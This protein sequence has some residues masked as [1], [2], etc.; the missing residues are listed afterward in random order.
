[1]NTFKRQSKID[2]AM[3]LLL[4][5]ITNKYERFARTSDF[6]TVEDKVQKFADELNVESGRKYIKIIAGT[7]VWGF[8][9]IANPD[10][11]YGDILKSKNWKTPALNQA[12]GN[13]FD[14]VYSID[15]TGPLYISGY[16]AG[17][18]RT[19]GKCGAEIKNL[20]GG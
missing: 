11:E 9:N 7:S 1:M 20:L 4:D 18:Q 15:W 10:F 3:D 17:G 5:N 8:I 16:S 6:S 14:D 2:T 13:I 12:R 19:C